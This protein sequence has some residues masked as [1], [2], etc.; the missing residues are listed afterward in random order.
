MG[1]LAWVNVVM[2]H[3]AL[4][5]V[6]RGIAKGHDA[7][8]WIEREGTSREEACAENPASSRQLWH[9]HFSKSRAV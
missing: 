2:N 7:A 5:L 9:R 4:R 8:L 6:L 1:P 3:E